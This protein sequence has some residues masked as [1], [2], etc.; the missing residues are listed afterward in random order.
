MLCLKLFIQFI[1]F[2]LVIFYKGAYLTLKSI[3]HKALKDGIFAICYLRSQCFPFN[4]EYYTRKPLESFFNIF[5]LT[6][7]FIRNW[8]LE[9]ARSKPALYHSAIKAVASHL[10]ETCYTCSQWRV[11]VHDIDLWVPFQGFLILA[12]DND[13]S[14]PSYPVTYSN[15]FDN[16]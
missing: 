15:E 12:L 16:T 2:V 6:R 13:Q 10:N 4:V 1:G 7:S 8:T 5:G 9:L 11:D 3:F 14:L